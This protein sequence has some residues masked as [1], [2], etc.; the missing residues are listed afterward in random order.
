[1]KISVAIISLSALAFGLVFMTHDNPVTTAFA[2]EAAYD[3]KG[4]EPG[5]EA[6]ERLGSNEQAVLEELEQLEQQV[7]SKGSL[8]I[9]EYQEVQSRLD[10][11]LQRVNEEAKSN[12][13][14]DVELFG[15]VLE[16]QEVVVGIDVQ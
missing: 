11:L 9:E 2:Q 5:P 10:E 7:A 14:P 8:T 13:Q 3:S 12:G 6:I 4:Y 15:E 1:M 16:L